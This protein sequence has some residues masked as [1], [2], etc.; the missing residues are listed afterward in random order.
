MP[1]SGVELVPGSAGDGVPAITRG[2]QSLAAVVGIAKAEHS[3]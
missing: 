1:P 2:A 3:F